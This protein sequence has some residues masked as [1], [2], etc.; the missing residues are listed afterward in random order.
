[1]ADI[2]MPQLGESV[3][4]GTITRWFKAPGDD[5]TED[6][7]LFEVSTDKVDTEVPAT[8][9]GVLGEIRVPEGE[10]VDVGT[11]L[12]VMADGSGAGEAAAPAAEAPAEAPA[13]PAPVAEA[14]AE[15]AARAR[16]RGPG[17]RSGAA[18]A[19]SLRPPLPPRN[20]LRHPP[21]LRP[22]PRS[23][24]RRRLRP[25]RPRAA[26]RS[27]RRWSGASSRRT[28]SIRRPSRAPESAGGSPGTTS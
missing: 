26:E 18:P 2:V 9:S 11:V 16:G 14:P 8:M 19:R 20:R 28:G 27:C 23:P 13:A 24:P 3:T 6:E 7:P 21:R 10:T 17:T 1:M 25:P 15:A 5:V 22:K 12:A 4:E